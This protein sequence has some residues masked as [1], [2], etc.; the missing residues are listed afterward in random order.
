MTAVRYRK[1]VVQAMGHVRDDERVL[2]ISLRILRM[3]V[4]DASHRQAM[5][6]NN[7]DLSVLSDHY[8]QRASSSSSVL[9]RNASPCCVDTQA[10]WGSLPAPGP[11]K[12]SVSS[13]IDNAPSLLKFESYKADQT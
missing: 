11:K 5:Q 1:F 13:L 6:V 4:G 2:L 12:T 9:F 7:R 8:R 3:Q 10:Q